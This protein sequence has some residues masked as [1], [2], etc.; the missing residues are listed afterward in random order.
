MVRSARLHV[1]ST[2]HRDL[3]RFDD[4][5]RALKG[6]HCWTCGEVWHI[7]VYDI[8][9]S[10]L[11]QQNILACAELPD[12][13]DIL[14]GILNAEPEDRYLYQDGFPSKQVSLDPIIDPPSRY[15]RDEPL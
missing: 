1:I 9:S 15:E 5:D 8:A 3:D 4:D 10:I 14:L 2:G 11:R 6:Y 7:T 13:F 12:G